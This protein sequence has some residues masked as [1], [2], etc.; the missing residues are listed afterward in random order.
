MES[1]E[2][3]YLYSINNK[4]GPRKTLKVNGVLCDFLLDMG[5]SVNVL[6]QSTHVKIGSP[7]LETETNPALLPYGGGKQLTVLGSSDC[8]LNEKDPYKHSN[9]MLSRAA[10]EPS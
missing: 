7:L 8:K 5:A 9:F 4:K 1:S 10:T 3:E 6:D 2:E